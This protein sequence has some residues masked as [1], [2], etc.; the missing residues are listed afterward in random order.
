[1]SGLG[2]ESERTY[3][4]RTTLRDVLV[5]AE[6]RLTAAGVPSPGHDAA[7][8]AAHVLGTTRTRLLLHDE[9]SPD[10]RVRLEALVARRLS[11]VPLQ[12]LVGTAPFR[13]LELLV[14]PGVFVPRPE[15][16]LV[17]EAAVRA[18]AARPEG[19]RVAVDLCAGSGALALALATEVPGSQ[20]HAVEVDPAAAEWTTRNIEAQADRLATAGSTVTLHVDD[21]TT[22]A[23]PGG[24]LST[25][26][27]RVAVV[28]TNPPY[29][30]DGA[31]PRDP[32]VRLHDPAR[33]LYG[34][35]D[36]LV[37]VR[38]LLRQA[39]V[40]LGPGGLLVVE[41]GDEQGPE[42]GAAGVPGMLAAEVADG[43]LALE[44]HTPAGRPLWAAVDDRPDL[45]R[46][47][48]FTVAVRA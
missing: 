32:E 28:A 41:H 36:G 8:L 4:G 45:N 19:H 22:C 14:G 15:T 21:A 18:L 24:P 29:V 37:V 1:M 9:L 34:G 38:G 35:P 26:A 13:R 5:D 11:R 20:V 39:A 42:A 23:E 48:R 43:S 2:Y 17:A 30:P 27:G 44:Q 3:G 31:V 25:L 47:P 12:H 10:Q 16:E 6:Q 40:L 33:A 46:R 7:E